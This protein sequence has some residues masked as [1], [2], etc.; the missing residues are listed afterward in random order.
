MNVTA[1]STK[2]GMVDSV[3]QQID[4]G[5]CADNGGYWVEGTVIYYG[6]DQSG[7]YVFTSLVGPSDNLSVVNTIYGPDSNTNASS[8]FDLASR[9]V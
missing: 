3:D 7:N 9:H 8:V 2:D 4:S 6:I 1:K 5:G